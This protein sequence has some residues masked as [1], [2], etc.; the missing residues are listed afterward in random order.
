[1]GHGDEHRDKHDKHLEKRTVS[2]YEAA[3]AGEIECE[4]VAAS[5]GEVAWK[6]SDDNPRGE[7]LRLRLRPAG[8][9]AFI[10]SDTPMDWHRMLEAVRKAADASS[11]F[12]PGQFVGCRV[13]VVLKHYTAKD[14]TTRAAVAKWL[15]RPV[16]V[17]APSGNQSPTLVDAI[18]AWERQPVSAPTRAPV[19]KP[20]RN[21]P[22]QYGAD[23]DIPF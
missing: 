20:S 3:P 14:G 6:V 23:D 8:N 11:D 13:R 22:P 10:F 15:P 5:I 19:A 9:Y 17:K 7:C 1:M 16:A 18:K 21:A 12:T 4:I 2:Q